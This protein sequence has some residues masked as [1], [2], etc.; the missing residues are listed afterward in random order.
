MG[1][2]ALFGEKYGDEVR[3]VSMGALPGSG[4]GTDGATYSIELCGG[5][6]V[7]RLGEIGAFVALGDAAIS[8]GVRRVE[9]LTGQAALDHLRTQDRRMAELAS[10]FKAAPDEVGERVRA[11]ADERKALQ[12]EVATLRREKASSGVEPIEINGLRAVLQV[13]EGVS[14]KDLG[15]MIDAQK[16]ALGSGVVALIADTGGK[17][18]V[19]IGVTSD[20]TGRVSAVDLVKVAV[21]RLGGRGGGGRPEL[22]QGGGADIAG[23]EAALAAVREA[24][25]GA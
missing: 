24:L 11:M 17:P 23:A 22:A 4:K 5:T 20:L 16:R 14:G 13:V 21:E 18:A 9:A 7:G 10:F 3:V 2:R 25:A 1:A 6:H 8:A 12:A 15:P 19:A